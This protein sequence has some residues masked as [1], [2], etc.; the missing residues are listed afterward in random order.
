MICRDFNAR[1]GTLLIR[2]DRLLQHRYSV[3]YRVSMITVTVD[4]VN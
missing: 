4:D 3:G 1:Y 2:G